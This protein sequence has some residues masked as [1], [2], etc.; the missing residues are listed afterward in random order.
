MIQVATILWFVVI[1]YAIV[2]LIIMSGQIIRV[3]N[4]FFF[5]RFLLFFNEYIFQLALLNSQTL[6]QYCLGDS[7]CK[8]SVGLT[9]S[10]N[11]RLKIEHDNLHFLFN[12]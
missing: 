12:F 2:T 1:M 8:T 10:C 11:K 4:D 5:E 7:A 6:Y 9:C 3:V